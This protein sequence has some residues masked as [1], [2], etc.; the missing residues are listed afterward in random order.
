[1]VRSGGDKGERVECYKRLE[2]RIRE[3][4]SG[5][6]A[7]MK[8][9]NKDYKG[10]KE[11]SEK[12]EGAIIGYDKL[13]SKEL[14]KNVGIGVYG[15]VTKEE[16]VQ[17]DDKGEATSVGVGVYGGITR[18]KLDIRGLLEGGYG[19][20]ESEREIGKVAKEIKIKEYDNI[21]VGK[22]KG[23]FGAKYIG[24]D[25]EG[26]MNFSVLEGKFGVRPYVGIEGKINK[27]EG[28]K[29]E[30][31]QV[32]ALSIKEGMYNRILG[33]LGV[34][35]GQERSKYDWSMKLEYKRL[36]S[37]GS[38]EIMC[39]FV[40]NN[41][42]NNAGNSEGLDKIGTEISGRYKVSERIGINVGVGLELSENNRNIE[43]NIGLGYKFGVKPK[44][45]KERESADKAKQK[46]NE[47][48]YKIL[49]DR[50]NS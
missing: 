15:E 31:V 20:Y 49:K 19:T 21:G 18:G 30:G 22:A 50:L 47:Y 12:E 24:M 40:N 8:K 48:L 46:I 43:G 23:K 4:K 7:K 10:K 5:I 27:Y 14:G 45:S 41:E 29:E 38:P 13:V 39:G 25:V 35:I 44:V 33:R 34:M 42:F 6:W 2:E 37:G 1:M 17:L 11:Y 28:M 32:F 26:G 9:G 3:G 16:M 36:M